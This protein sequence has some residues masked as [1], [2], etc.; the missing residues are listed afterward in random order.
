MDARL[1]IA[2]IGLGEIAEVAYLDNLHNPG[3]GVEVAHVCDI[4]PERLK[5][6]AA[7][8]PTA[9]ATDSFDDILRD[10]EVNWVFILTPLLMHAALI[11]KAL[12]AG[13]NVYTEKPISVKFDEAA[14]L[15]DLSKRKG[16]YLASAPILL[17]YP[18]YEYARQLLLGGAIGQ[19]TSA[20]AIVAHGG[21]NAWPTTTDLGWLFTKEEATEMPPL[22]DLGIYAFSWLAHVFGPANRVT[23]MAA[24]A[25]KERTFDKVTAPGFKPYT[26]QVKVKDSTVVLLEFAHGVLASVTSNF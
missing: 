4:K 6:G 19:L 23:A 16:L 3:K 25:I 24:L 12:N 10:R 5:W 15:V 14:D 2:V 18:V 1:K 7:K 13:K 20:R 22:P 8:V 11:K 21:P 26:M 9:E 17:L